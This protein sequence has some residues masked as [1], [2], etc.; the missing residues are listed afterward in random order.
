MAGISSFGVIERPS[1]NVEAKTIGIGRISR[2]RK[3]IEPKKGIFDA[4]FR[5]ARER[6][7]AG[8]VFGVKN[9]AEFS[10]FHSA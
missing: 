1:A 6:A 5:Q 3:R 8:V 2:G 10:N 7:R 9:C 4:P